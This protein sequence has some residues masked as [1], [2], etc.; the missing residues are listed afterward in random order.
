MRV[1][2]RRIVIVGAGDAAFDYALNLSRFNRVTILNR[3]GKTRCLPLLRERAINHP[4]ITYKENTAIRRIAGLNRR[5][6]ELICR[7]GDKNWP[8]TA[9]YVIFAI[10]RKANLD[11]LSPGLRK[12]ITRLE[13]RSR[14]YLVGDVK[15]GDFRQAVIAA[16]EGMRA[17][18]RIAWSYRHGLL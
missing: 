15:G 10:G 1:R 9:D 16:G 18:M 13:E 8:V 7:M 3:T 6:M 2:N 12:R 11:F 5:G 4:G 17:G 14:L